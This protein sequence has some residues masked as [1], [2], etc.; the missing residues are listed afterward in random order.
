MKVLEGAVE[1]AQ[2]KHI[3]ANCACS[4]STVAT[5]WKRI[6][7]KTGMRPQ[8]EVLAHLLRFACELMPAEEPGCGAESNIRI[9]ID[10]SDIEAPERRPCRI[11][12]A[13]AGGPIGVRGATT[14]LRERLRE[15]L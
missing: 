4:R 12:S 8:R 7:A 9:R 1:G 6:F 3:A 10:R 15:V 2:D 13:L 5:Y 11:E 14:T